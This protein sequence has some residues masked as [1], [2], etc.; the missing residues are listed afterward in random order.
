[1]IDLQISSESR[2]CSTMVL[3]TEPTKRPFRLCSTM[4]LDTE[5]TKRPV[6]FIL[7]QKISYCQM[8]YKNNDKTNS[9]KE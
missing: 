6:L 8:S 7:R 1:M 4:V 9:F 3:E 5:P 2:F